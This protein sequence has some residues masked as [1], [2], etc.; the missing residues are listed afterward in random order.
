MTCMTRWLWR[1]AACASVGLLVSTTALAQTGGDAQ[2]DSKARAHFE[3]GEAHYADGEFLEAAEQFEKA[4]SLSPMPVLLYNA[5]LA[6]RDANKLQKA[7][8]TLER[9]LE[10]D[11]EAP[12]REKL[13]AVL[14]GLRNGPEGASSP[15][16]GE[17]RQ[18]EGAAGAGDAGTA[19]EGEK[20]KMSVTT[21]VLASEAAPIEGGHGGSRPD[22]QHDGE[23]RFGPWP[24][25]VMAGGGALLAGALVTGLLRQDAKNELEGQCSQ[26]VCPPELESTQDRGR[27]LSVI[28]DV[29]WI[30]G[31]ASVGTGLVLW[32]IDHGR[33]GEHASDA[34]RPRAD[35]GCSTRGCA[36][37]LEVGF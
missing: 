31:L 17:P 3:L 23:P 4:H 2:D 34:A 33:S 37:T 22:V 29:L 25:V 16:R 21:E 13:Q 28:T 9:Y 10:A 35:V 11:P 15:S 1:W 20:R 18:S 19:S 5:Y 6:Y 26:G 30:S 12:N 7:A 36:A 27:R 8:D 32:V 14:K 24:Y